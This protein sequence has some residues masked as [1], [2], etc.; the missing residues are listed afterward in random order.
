MESHSL[1]NLYEVHGL[2]FWNASEHHDF[3]DRALG[4]F[5]FSAFYNESCIF[6]QVKFHIPS[7]LVV[8]ESPHM[9]RATQALIS[10]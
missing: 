4:R 1:Y 10:R 8:D 9:V 3:P 5:Y 7:D 2:S 6:P